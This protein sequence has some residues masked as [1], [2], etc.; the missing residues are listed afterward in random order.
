MYCVY[1]TIG[2]RHFKNVIF[3]RIILVRQQKEKSVFSPI[4]VAASLAENNVLSVTTYLSNQRD[5]RTGIQR[6]RVLQ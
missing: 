2:Y 6:Y 4:S 1:I 3:I 5:L